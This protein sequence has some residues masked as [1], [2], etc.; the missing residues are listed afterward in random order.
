MQLVFYINIQIQLAMLYFMWS[1][2][3]GP[4]ARVNK[5]HKKELNHNHTQI[6]ATTLNW[7]EERSTIQSVKITQLSQSL[8]G[9]NPPNQTK[10][11][12]P[13]SL[14]PLPSLQKSQV[15]SFVH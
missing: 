6:H 11:D 9:Q 15:Y 7:K 2:Q 10:I 3:T 14:V 1:Q 4:T 13:L 5:A 8:K 12:Q